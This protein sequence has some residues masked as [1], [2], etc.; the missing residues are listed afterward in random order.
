MPNY[1]RDAILVWTFVLIAA[2]LVAFIVVETG[3]DENKAAPSTRATPA[4]QTTP[5]PAAGAATVN[6]K[7]IPTIRFDVDEITL[8]ANKEVTVRAD[9]QDGSTMH[10][11]AAY[12]DSSAQE[13]IAKT[14]ICAAPCVEE[15]TF[16]TPPPGEYFFR[17]DVHPTQMV[18][19][20]LIQ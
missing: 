4:V 14:Q 6:I 20:L 13:S 2:G 17:C 11:W 19:R 16:K 1:T 10:N 5:S 9:N 7:M 15:I 8:P 18:G 3:G 12:T